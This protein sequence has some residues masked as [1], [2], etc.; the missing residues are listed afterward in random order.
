MLP[1][2]CLEQIKENYPKRKGGYGWYDLERHLKARLRNFTWDQI[3]EGTKRYKKFAINEEIFGTPFVMQP[4]RFYGKGC[5]FSE[6][7]ETEI[8]VAHKPRQPEVVTPEMKAEDQ[9][10]FEEQIKRFQNNG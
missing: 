10:K 1:K 8:E 9:R 7:W 2:N 6:D 3:I 4:T 5:Y